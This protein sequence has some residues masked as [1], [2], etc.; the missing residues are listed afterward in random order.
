MQLQFTATE[1]LVAI[2]NMDVLKANGFELQVD[3]KAPPTRR[4]K[5]VAQPMSK[6]TVF[7]TKG[8]LHSLYLLSRLDNYCIIELTRVFNKRLGRVDFFIS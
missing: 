1:E 3:D 6:N 2:E 4:L 5:L 7:G 8:Y